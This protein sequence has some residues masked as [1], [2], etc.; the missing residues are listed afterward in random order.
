GHCG[1]RPGVAMF[2]QNFPVARSRLVRFFPASCSG[3]ENLSLPR[4]K[5]FPA[6]KCR[7]RPAGDPMQL[8]KQRFS[9]NEAEQLPSPD[10]VFSLTA[11]NIAAARQTEKYFAWGWWTMMAEVD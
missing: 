3:G 8:A 5:N 2:R 9:G 6:G 7:R 4:R 1:A 10:A 11:G